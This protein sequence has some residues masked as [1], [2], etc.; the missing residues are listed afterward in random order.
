MPGK[1]VRNLKLVIEDVKINAEKS[2]SESGYAHFQEWLDQDPSHYYLGEFGKGTNPH[3]RR[4]V[5]N[6]VA[7]GPCY[8]YKTYGG[9][10]VILTR[11]RNII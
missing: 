4:S 10:V 2:F 1:Y 5:V 9:H 3:L 7:S 8:T 6:R 11:C